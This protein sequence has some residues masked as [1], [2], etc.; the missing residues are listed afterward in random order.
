MSTFVCLFSILLA[1]PAAAL[2]QA[3][4]PPP[5]QAP[6]PR[7]LAE[8]SG[9]KF[10]ERELEALFE[11]LPG[12]NKQ[13]L[14]S[15]QKLQLVKNWMQVVAF[16]KEAEAKGL[17]R[18]PMILVHMEMFR[19][20]VLFERYQKA[21]LSPLKVTE[22]ETRKFFDE[23]KD[24]FQ[25]PVQ[26]KVSRILVPTKEKADQVRQAAAQGTPFDQ[27]AREHSTE[28]VSKQRGGEIGWVQPGYR[29]ADLFR[30][31]QNLEPNQISES[32]S[33][34]SGW[35]VAKVTDKRPSVQK[36]Y[37]EVQK[38]ISQQLL[39]KKQKELMDTTAAE[40]FKKYELKINE[41]PK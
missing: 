17:D 13:A 9:Y 22:E 36:E 15:D 39:T 40:L 33:S 41:A 4:N 11:V 14:T 12:V 1:L 28:E 20:R 5:A 38:I 2:A 7:T 27:L 31:V 24:R 23:N 34:A 26:L 3:D 30:A 37:S 8:M 16:S 25:S 21:L 19:R 18:D 10:T 6:E 29:D 35:Q 32:F